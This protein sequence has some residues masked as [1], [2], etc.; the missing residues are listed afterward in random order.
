MAVG[1]FFGKTMVQPDEIIEKQAMG[2]F[3]KFEKTV[4]SKGSG[5]IEFKNGVFETI[6]KNKR[7]ISD[8]P[9]RTPVGIGKPLSIELLCVYTG[10]APNKFLGRKKDLIV[11]SGIKDVR[12]HGQYTKAINM[13][14]AKEK[15][16]TRIY[17]SGAVGVPLVYYTPALDIGTVFCNIEMVA[18]TFNEKAFDKIGDAFNMAASVPIFLTSN[19]YLL[20]GSAI[21][22]IGKKLGNKFL[23][24]KA[25]LDG[26]FE[27][28]FDTPGVPIS[29]SDYL[30]VYNDGQHGEFQEF[31]PGMLGKGVNKKLAL[32]HDET[33]KEYDGEE[34]YI[35]LNI[36]GRNRDHEFKDF[37]PKAISAAFSEKFYGKGASSNSTEILEEAIMLL[38]DKTYYN[39]AKEAIKL[40]KKLVPNSKEYKNTK[41]LIEAYKANIQSGYFKV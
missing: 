24:S 39:K 15:D 34:P 41:T 16:Y 1:Y 23:E 37:T 17:P 3:S 20:A 19:P 22:K 18:D 30:I 27:L 29:I 14:A 9:E 26:A 33:G 28:R 8:S 21:T 36:D 25:F 32:I 35:L 31:S 5:K 38:N 4:K 12:T 13:I 10:N 40:L 7:S 11:V 6:K 2:V